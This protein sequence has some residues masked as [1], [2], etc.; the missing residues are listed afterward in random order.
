MILCF[1]GMGNTRY[2]ADQ[3][4]LLTDDTVTD[5]NGLIRQGNMNLLRGR[6]HMHF[7]TD[8]EKEMIFGG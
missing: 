5:M 8:D 2:V 7:L 3:I 1:S 6:G 4:A